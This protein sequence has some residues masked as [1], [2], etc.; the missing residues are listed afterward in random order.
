[1]ADFQRLTRESLPDGVFEQL[2]DGIVAGDLPGGEAL[3]S[4]RRLAEAF[5]VSRPAVREALKR[6]AQSGMI[7]IRQGE[8]TTVRPWRRTAG[9]ELLPR[10]LLR[11]DGSVDLR[12]A[13]SILEV[14][15]AVGPDIAARAA[16]RHGGEED[17]ASRLAGILER[18]SATDDAV[19]LQLAAVDFWDALVDASD[20]VAYRLMTNAL[21]S[22]Y[23]PLVEGLA[24]VMRVEV[25]NIDG[26]RAVAAAVTDG[27]P[28]GARAAADHLLQA[29]TGAVLG[30]ID[31]LL[32]ADEDGQQPNDE[33]DQ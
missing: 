19:E 14:R 24:E 2:V 31:N 21:T 1:M 7:A 4:E 5:G 20:N 12:V 30:A 28:A 29:G 16:A 15:Q 9:P 10:L 3:P 26:Y 8:S 11:R 17:L 33:D 18:L 6:L 27:N 13:R 23:A 32:A 22:A 25:S